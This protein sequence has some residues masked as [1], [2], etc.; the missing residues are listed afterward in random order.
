[1]DRDREDEEGPEAPAR[2]SWLKRQF[3]D[4]PI[5]AWGLLAVGVGVIAAVGAIVVVNETSEPKDTPITCVVYER[6]ST[7]RLTI[8]SMV[9]K[10]EA[11]QGCGRS[12]QGLSS[13]AA[14]FVVGTPPIPEEEPQEICALTSPDQPTTMIVEEV[15]DVLS[16]G[17]RICG[18]LAGEGW[19]QAIDAPEVGPGQREYIEAVEAEEVVEA[20]QQREIEIEEG[21]REERDQALYA[22]EER[23]EAK[24]EAE[25]EAIERET[26][27][28]IAAAPESQEYE[29]EEEGYEREEEAYERELEAVEACEREVEAEAGETEYR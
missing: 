15:P 4:K 5:A 11:E 24:E 23:A 1:M 6:S 14:F 9:T 18:A 10:K 29:I 13:A 28:R 12:T 26:E 8:D 21:E 17:E 2:P 27:E 22:C 3:R 16:K 20:E 7:L 19:S 25:L